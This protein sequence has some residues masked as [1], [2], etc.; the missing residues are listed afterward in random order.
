MSDY[1]M[2]YACSDCQCCQDGCTNIRSCPV[3]FHFHFRENLGEQF[4]AM[5]VIHGH[6]FVILL[7]CNLVAH[8]LPVDD[9]CHLVFASLLLV[10]LHGN[11]TDGNFPSMCFLPVPSLGAFHL[12]EVVAV[13]DTYFVLLVKRS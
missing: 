13:N 10:R 6:E 5:V 2:G 3:S 7:L 4:H 9:S 1:G 12:F 8:S 11:L